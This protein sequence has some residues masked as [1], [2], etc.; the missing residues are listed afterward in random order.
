MSTSISR[1]MHHAENLESKLARIK[2]KSEEQIGKGISTVETVGAC[3]LAGYV[4][5]RFGTAGELQ[6]N[7]V[8]VDLA[9]GIAG[10]VLSFAGLAGKHGDHVH[11]VANGLMSAYAYRAGAAAASKT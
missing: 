1:W 6:F 9:A 10:A 5:A 2:E 3:G 4:N 11:N 7:G 8:P